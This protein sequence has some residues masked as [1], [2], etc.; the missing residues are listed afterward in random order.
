MPRSHR[1]V[2]RGQCLLRHQRTCD[3]GSHRQLRRRDWHPA[4]VQPHDLISR[5]LQ[6][7]AGCGVNENWSGGGDGH[8]CRV[9]RSA[10]EV[11][12][13]RMERAGLG[14]HEVRS[15]VEEC[16]QKMVD[17]DR[18]DRELVGYLEGPEYHRSLALVHAEN[19]KYHDLAVG[20][21][22]TFS[23]LIDN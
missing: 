19:C 11:E 1:L 13:R 14:F 7:V 18:V 17:V 23:P 9:M 20:P 16:A 6:T 3:R 22:S 15:G 10:R 4:L 5:P 2:L 21:T 8:G 12:V